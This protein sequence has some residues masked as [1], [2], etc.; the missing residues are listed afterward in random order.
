MKNFQEEIRE[1]LKEILI[2]NMGVLTAFE[3]G[4]AATGYLDEYS[5]LDLGLIV[6]DEAIESIFELVEKVLELNY[7]IKNKFRMPEPNWHGHSQCFYILEKSPKLFYL[8]MLIEKESATNRFLESDR[9]G[10]AI[11]WFDKKN[12]IDQAETP[13]KITSEK[14]KKQYL[15]IKETIPFAILDVKKQIL[16]DNKID[17]FSVYYGIVNRLVALMNIKYRPAKHD[18]GVRYLYR[19]FPKEEFQFVE[20]LMFVKTLDTLAI[21]LLDIESRLEELFDEFEREF[22]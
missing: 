13:E 18:F 2:D 16:R 17:A 3:G 8:D 12:L 1:N 6:S 9:H 20:N 14:C 10:K 21:N 19:D 11:V 15:R 5:D 7:G 22:L 4:S